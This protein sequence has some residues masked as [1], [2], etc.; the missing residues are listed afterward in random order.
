MAPEAN[1]SRVYL[2]KQENLAATIRKNKRNVAINQK[3]GNL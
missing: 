2:K 1:D 3:R